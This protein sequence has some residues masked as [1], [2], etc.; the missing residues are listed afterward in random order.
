MPDK[1]LYG[2]TLI[3]RPARSFFFIHQP[4][5]LVMAT[6]PPNISTTKL[7]PWDEYKGKKPDEALLSI[8]THIGQKSKEMCS[9]YWSS[10]GT[11]RNTS[12]TIRAF[13]FVFLVI[14]TT[15]PVI[16]AALEK[17]DHKLIITQLGVAFLVVAG[18]F[19]LSDRIFGWSSGWMRYIATVT[20]MENLTR[21]FEMEWASYLVSKYVLLET[22]DVKTLFE[23]ART[24]EQELTKLQAEETTKW[25]AEFNTSISLLESMIKSQREETDKKLDTI[26]TNLTSQAAA[27][28]AED[29]LNLPG[30]IEVSFVYK[31]DPKRI[32]IALGSKP[33]VE[34]LGY[35]WSE[36]NVA[37]G[38]HL[39][40]IEIMSDPPQ[41]MT[42]VIDVLPAA[43][44]R[45]TI[46]FAA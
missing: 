29:K 13:A 41:K 19:T 8:Y 34:F 46:T 35:T 23:L 9:W 3:H 33:L 45:T 16:S 27:A 18:L 17:A 42:K 25:I 7:L 12:L 24:L 2:R 21:A 11:K 30:A 38:Q 39:L 22:A 4:G 5:I 44:A 6:K 32:R 43:T 15:L 36:L 10:I 1:I 28:K 37:P 20:T 40:S 14:G 31:A 26:R